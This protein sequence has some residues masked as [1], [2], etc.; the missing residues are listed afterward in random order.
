MKYLRFCFIL[1]LLFIISI[2]TGCA[3][4]EMVIRQT[5]QIKLN[6]Y[7]DFY[8]KTESGIAEDITEELVQLE[9]EVSKK[10]SALNKFQ[11]FELGIPKETKPNIISAKA[12][13]TKINKV[14]GLATF[15][16]GVFAGREQITIEITFTDAATGKNVCAFTVNEGSAKISATIDFAAEKIAETILQNYQ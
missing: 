3:A 5:A 2:L 11:H 4:P 6:Q 10:V 12:V 1:F 14:S 8:F 7:T 16:I 9:S 13:I 15:F